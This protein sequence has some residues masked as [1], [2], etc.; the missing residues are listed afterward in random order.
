VDVKSLIAYSSVAHMR[1]V[2]LSSLV[3]VGPLTRGLVIVLVG[4]GVIRRGLFCCFNRLYVNSF[5][6]SLLI[7]SGLV[8]T[9]IVL[10][11]ILFLTLCGNASVPPSVS[12]VGEA[13]MVGGV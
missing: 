10:A 7:N 4:H 8:K 2:C 12:L 9:N 11:A 6:R 13:L 3:Y 1:L 5:S